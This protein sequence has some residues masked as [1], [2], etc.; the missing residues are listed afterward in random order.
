MS[1]EDEREFWDCTSAEYNYIYTDT[2]ANP[3]YDNPWDDYDPV[4]EAVAIVNGAKEE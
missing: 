3:Y 2:T 1:G 4:A